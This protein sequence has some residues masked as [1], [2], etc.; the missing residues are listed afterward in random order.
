MGVLRASLIGGGIALMACSVRGRTWARLA[1]AIGG[2]YLTY[3]GFRARGRGA[4]ELRLLDHMVDES[5]K[6]SFPASDPPAWVN[7]G[8]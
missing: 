5:S 7:A 8:L 1:C 4:E 6:E 2:L 3:T